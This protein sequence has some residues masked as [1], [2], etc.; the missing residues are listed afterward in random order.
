MLKR[1]HHPKKMVRGRGRQGWSTVALK[2]VAGGICA[3]T[4]TRDMPGTQT[5]NGQFLRLREVLTLTKRRT[6]PLLALDGVSINWW[7]RK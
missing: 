2:I 1:K 7:A 5:L 6:Y 4:N 3:S